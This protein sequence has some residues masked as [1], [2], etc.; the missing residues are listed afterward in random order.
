MESLKKIIL[1]AFVG[2]CFISC[3]N[4]AGCSPTDVDTPNCIY[5]LDD[6]AF[7][8]Q[9]PDYENKVFAPK[10]QFAYFDKEKVIECCIVI[11]DKN[12]SE[13]FR[14]ATFTSRYIITCDLSKYLSTD[15]TTRYNVYIMSS[16][17]KSSFNEFKYTYSIDY[18]RYLYIN[19]N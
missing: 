18:Y 9:N 5:E 15:G 12:N 13:V 14:T 11:K 16:E 10:I 17:D 8:I 7:S 6:V 4:M 19:E 1:L 3:S 2:I